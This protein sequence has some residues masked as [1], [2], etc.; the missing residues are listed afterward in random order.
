MR[1][2]ELIKTYD[3]FIALSAISDDKIEQAERILELRF[4]DE[5][6][7]FISSYGSAC[8]NGHEFLGIGESE[9]TG[10]VKSTIKEKEKNPNVSSDMYLIENYGIDS[11][12]IW[13][14]SKG[15]LFQTVGKGVPIR[16]DIGLCE[17][18]KE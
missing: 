12:K 3:D 8:A 1:F 13:Q 15:E 14:N 2:V 18:V 9:Q 6:R 4:A 11:L 16:I 5:Y 17:F 10:I 7:E